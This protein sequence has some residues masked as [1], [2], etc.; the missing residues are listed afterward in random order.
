MADISYTSMGNRKFWPRIPQLQ[1]PSMH[2]MAHNARMP[3]SYSTSTHVGIFDGETVEHAWA[4]PHLT[5]VPRKSYWTFE[6]I[7]ARVQAITNLKKRWY[8]ASTFCSYGTYKHFIEDEVKRKRYTS[9]DDPMK[10]WRADKQLFLDHLHRHDGLGDYHLKPACSLCDAEYI[11]GSSIRLF[12]CEACGQFLQCMHCLEE[13]HMLNPLHCVKEWNGDFWTNVALHKVHIRDET[14]QSLNFVYQLGHHGKPCICPASTDPHTM[15]VIDV[16][17]VF[18]LCV[19]LCG[20]EKVLRQDPIAQ[21]MANGWYPAT[22]IDPATCATFVCLEQFRLLNVVGNLSAHDYVGTLE[23]LTDTTLLG[24]TPDRYKAFSRMSRQYQFLKR[25]KRAG[26]GHNTGGM[27]E[28]KPGLGLLRKEDEYLYA[29]MLALDANFR[30]KNRI[31]TNERHDPSLGS[32]WGYFV[33]SE[34]YK[35][36]L[37]DYVAEVDVSTCIAFAALMQKETRLTSGLRVSGVGGCVCA[38]HGVVRAQG[39]G[40]LQ[41]GER[42]ANMDYI[43]LHAL[44]DTRVKELVLDAGILPDLSDFHIKF[45][46]PVWHA[47]AHEV[48]CQAALSLSYAAGVGRTDGEGIERTWAT[49]NPISFATKEMGEGNRHDSI[50]DKIDHVNFEKNVREGDTLGRKL[51]IA[52]AERNKQIAEF[53][54]IDRGLAPALRREW[55][56]G[57]NDW[58]ADSTKP[59]P[60][61]MAGGKDAGLSEAQVAADLR[62]AEVEEAREGRGHFF[63]GENN[64]NELHQGYEVR[65]KAT[66]TADRT[67]QIE[68]LRATFF[69]K[70]KSIHWEQDLFMPG[71]AALMAAEEERRDGELPP[72]KAEDVKLWLPSDLT[73]LQQSWACKGGL[74]E[75]EAK[76]RTAQCGDALAKIRGLLYTKTHLIHTRNAMAVGQAATTRSSTLIERAWTAMRR[77]KGE[78]YAPTL[79][80]LK[81]GDLHVRTETESD[82]RGAHTAGRLGESRRGRNEPTATTSEG[83]KGVSWIWSAVQNEDD[84]VGLHKA[85]RVHWAKALARRDRWVKEELHKRELF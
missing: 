57:V 56:Q 73:E 38:R 80:E 82:A 20:C 77:L 54:E 72:P 17:G 5:D 40:D 83:A 55:Q 22:T 64:S 32:G 76:L 9:S 84:E 71:V 10:L 78:G 31:R 2:A 14:P 52:V 36:H 67:S 85:V 24:S 49:L 1:L 21:L 50:E 61:V 4:S 41:K 47:A 74:L 43:L 8:I 68:E 13:R 35:E 16:W 66:L 69:K 12:R 62:K 70:L 6:K 33:E 11:A 59:N 65:G 37:R 58:L 39:V 44:G 18:T 19:R 23:R 30:L 26:V 34:P 46:L 45:A 28:V 51:I 75:V 27:G 53:V 81:K 48:N 42:Y 25:A 60:Y 7:M 79:K 15:V 29:L 3:E 63:D